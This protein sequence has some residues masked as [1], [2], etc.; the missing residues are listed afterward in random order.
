ML[1]RP[2]PRYLTAAITALVL[3]A[4]APAVRAQYAYLE[5]MTVPDL[6]VPRL[7]Y[8]KNDFETEMNSYSLKGD[9]G[10]DSTRY[11]AAPAAGIAWDYFIY[12]PDLFSFQT[13]AEPGYSW[14]QYSGSQQNYGADSFL[15]NGNF[16]G[17]LLREKDYS[18]TLNYGRSHDD[19]HYDF[20]NS[21]TV[22]TETYNVATGYRAGPVPFTVSFTRT[23]ADTEGNRQATLTDQYNLQFHARNERHDRDVTDLAYQYNNLNYDTHYQTAS[24]NT[25]NTYHLVTVADTENYT[26]ST[27]GSSLRYYD[28]SSA[29][30]SSSDL[31]TAL[32]YNLDHTP[33]LRSFYNYDFSRYDGNGEESYQNYLTVGLT[34]QLY[35]SLSSSA[36]FH[37]STVNSDYGGSALNSQ[38]AGVGQSEDYTK[39]LGQW[40]RLALGNSLNYELNFQQSDV[41][42]FLVANESHNIPTSGP[43]IIRL[44]TPRAMAVVSIQKNNVT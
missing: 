34:H 24:Y 8:L 9:G 3:A 2:Q 36:N 19:Y 30:S 4:G 32:A 22:D 14:Q 5:G 21:A 7:R 12:H 11:Y 26:S 10:A 33:H 44:N 42:Q 37:G 6:T 43:M 20:F 38:A 25:E 40:G 16:T 39:Q 31:N 29:T 17:E 35:D 23:D 41:S 13:L 1:T 15:L 18:T 27:L 28:I